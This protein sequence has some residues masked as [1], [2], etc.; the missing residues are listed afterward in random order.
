MT[1]LRSLVDRALAAAA[2]VAL[3]AAP[4]VAAAQAAL[5]HILARKSI[6]IAIPTDFPPYGFL[7]KDSKP[8]GL[9]VDMARLVASKL[10]VELVLVPVT[11]P[12]RIPSLQARKADL[13]ISTLGRTPEREKAIDFTAAYSPFFHAV[14]GPKHLVVNTR[15][16]LAG[17]SIAVTR[18][19]LED[20]ALTKLA[21]SGTDIRRFED[22]DA[23]VAAFVAGRTQLIATGASVAGNMKAR[24]PTLDAQYKL[25][26][27]ESPNFI[28]V[29]KG[30][31]RLRT[32]VDGIIAD[33][34]RSGELDRLAAKWLGRP[35][36]DLP[37]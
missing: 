16:D 22:N 37:R 9:D 2:A 36:G 3:A 7:G 18:A 35:A 26:L 6:S 30:E 24:N 23:T 17:R 27:E 33:A 13:V 32:R 34:R 12:D 4:A 15:A 5:D 8:Q 19:T 31:D 21:P 28:G 20:Q 14:F 29:A 11:S 25:L 1:P 10:G